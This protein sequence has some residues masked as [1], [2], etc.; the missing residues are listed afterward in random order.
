MTNC[1][2]PSCLLPILLVLNPGRLQCPFWTVHAIRPDIRQLQQTECK[3]HI[4]SIHVLNQH[5]HYHELLLKIHLPKGRVLRHQTGSFCL[6]L[7]H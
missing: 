3:R 6:L 4:G 1:G 5:L 7:C 2:S